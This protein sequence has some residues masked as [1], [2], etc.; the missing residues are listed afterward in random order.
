MEALV[1]GPLEVLPSQLPLSYKTTKQLIRDTFI[2]NRTRTDEIKAGYTALDQ[3]FAALRALPLVTYLQSCSSHSSA[4][5]ITVEATSAFSHVTQSKPLEGQPEQHWFRYR[6]RI[7]N[8]R[9]HPI[10]VLGRGWV[11]SNHLGELE[12]HVG[13]SADNAIVGQQP[14][15]PPNSCF[16]YNSI[17]PLR[18]AGGPGRMEGQLIID[19]YDGSDETEAVERLKVP[20]APFKLQTMAVAG[21]G[22]R[23]SG[24]SSSSSRT[25]GSDSGGSSS[26][27]A[28]T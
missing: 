17:T 15:I 16:E 25:A 3:G 2:H 4:E 10:K 23:G 8:N 6:I 24:G 9:Q 26:S 7:T 22:R 21:A 20:V 1:P 14:V 12:G 13:L 27:S 19:L 28:Q 18:A 5:D 11:V